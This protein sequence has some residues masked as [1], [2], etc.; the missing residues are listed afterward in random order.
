VGTATPSAGL[1]YT[2]ATD[3]GFTVLSITAGTGTVTF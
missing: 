3:A 2:I 1:T